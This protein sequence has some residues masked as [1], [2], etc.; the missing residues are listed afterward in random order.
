MALAPDG[1]ALFSTYDVA[2]LLGV[3]M[4]TVIGWCKQKKLSAYKTPGGHRRIK[5][6]DLIQF[7]KGYN[8]PIPAILLKESSFRCLV[9]DDEPAI[10]SSVVRM[11]KEL[12]KSVE[13]SEAG[14]GFEAGKKVI[15]LLP[16]L[17]VLDLNLPGVDG[18][19]V[20][21]DI[22][23][24]ERFQHTKI[25][26]I[27]GNNTIETQKRILDAGADIFLPKPFDAEELKAK[28]LKLFQQVEVAP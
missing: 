10:R 8:M 6:A 19:R 14:D 11:L 3:D 27:S 13:V 25:L 7:L 22:R 24:D 17:V 2:K 23:K 9:V 5:A 15:D 21:E 4:T 28:I 1:P 20:C 18:F 26:A 16:Q 12:D